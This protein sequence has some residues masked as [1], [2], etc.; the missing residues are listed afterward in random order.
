MFCEGLAFSLVALVASLG[1][2]IAGVALKVSDDRAND[3]HRTKGLE[4]AEGSS[5]DLTKAYTG[6][7]LVSDQLDQRRLSLGSRAGR[8]EG[9][10]HLSPIREFDPYSRLPKSAPT[11][12]P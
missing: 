9:V 11:L 10:L 4:D 7:I 5:V 12:P 2:D 3:S 8:R 1:I 6:C